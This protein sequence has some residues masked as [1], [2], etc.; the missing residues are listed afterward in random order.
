MMTLKEVI[1]L[2][3]K[4]KQYVQEMEARIQFINKRIESAS[5]KPV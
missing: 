1:D 4:T 3:G 5:G 2:A